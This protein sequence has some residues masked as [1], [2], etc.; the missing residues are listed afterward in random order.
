MQRQAD[1]EE[2]VLSD[3]ALAALKEFA[4]ENNLGEQP[5]CHDQVPYL[6]RDFSAEVGRGVLTI[7]E[8]LSCAGHPA[9]IAHGSML[10][11][12]LPMRRCIRD[13]QRHATHR[14]EL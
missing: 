12:T 7:G 8:A 5:V 11:T 13:Q 6:A 4:F 9:V 3:A 1:E 10:P 14:S 2:L